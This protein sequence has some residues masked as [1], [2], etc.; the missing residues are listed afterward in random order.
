MTPENF[1][2]WLQGLLEVA[3]PETLDK[4]QLAIVREHLQLVFNKVTTK[5]VHD[6][7]FDKSQILQDVKTLSKEA[8]DKIIQKTYDEQLAE[9]EK[10]GQ[11]KSGNIAYESYGSIAEMKEA[12]GLVSWPPNGAVHDTVTGKQYPLDFFNVEYVPPRSC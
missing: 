1:C 7:K 9:I 4:N 6:I 10:V 2:Y 12:K 5:V 3:N 11:C 8:I